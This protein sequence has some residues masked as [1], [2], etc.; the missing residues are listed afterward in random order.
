MLI[1]YNLPVS[2]QRRLT[3]GHGVDHHRSAG[4][5]PLQGSSKTTEE[6][7]WLHGSDS[8]VY[9]LGQQQ[10]AGGER[11][12]GTRVPGY[13]PIWRLSVFLSYPG[14]ARGREDFWTRGTSLRRRYRDRHSQRNVDGLPSLT[15]HHVAAAAA[16]GAQRP[17]TDWT[18]NRCW[19]GDHAIGRDAIFASYLSTFQ[20][21]RHSSYKGAVER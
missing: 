3:R 4:T 19:G 12:G 10:R 6:K 18:E 8:D 5:S 21:D 13:N 17:K 15:S 9:P 1:A 11:V 16:T 7:L 2:Q 20:P 14:S